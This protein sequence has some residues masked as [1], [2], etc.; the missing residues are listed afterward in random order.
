MIWY[1]MICMIW[2]DMIWYNTIWCDM[3]Y[4]IS[5]D[6]IKYKYKYKYKYLLLFVFILDLIRYLKILTILESFLLDLQYSESDFTIPLYLIFIWF[7]LEMI[8]RSHPSSFL[9]LL[10]FYLETPIFDS[11]L[12]SFPLSIS[13]ALYSFFL[14]NH[15]L[16]YSF[17]LYR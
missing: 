6:C 3:M 9:L 11:F 1:D 13:S 16:L 10:K 17:F 5:V 12:T 7:L 4:C 8:F 15:S 2:Y 14:T